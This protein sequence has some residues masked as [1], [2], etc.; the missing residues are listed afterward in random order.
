MIFQERNEQTIEPLLLTGPQAARLL[1]VSPRTVFTLTKTRQ[2]VAV[3]IG[4]SVRYD[5]ADIRAWI[6]SAKN[7]SQNSQ[8]PS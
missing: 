5:P 1:N 6:A 7:N 2:L 3:K 4:R 8:N